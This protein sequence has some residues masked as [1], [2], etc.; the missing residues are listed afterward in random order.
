MVTGM[1]LNQP[2]ALICLSENANPLSKDDLAANLGATL[3]S[4]NQELESY[5]RLSHMV[6]FR[7][8]WAEDSGFFTPTLK[9]KRHIVDGH[10]GTHY[11]SW[12]SSKIRIVWAP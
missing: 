1:G 4:L 7:E 12:S 11:E 3:E 2:I 8:P 6:I 5:A 9:I 10:F